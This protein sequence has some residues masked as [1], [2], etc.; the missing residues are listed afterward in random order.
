MEEICDWAG[1]QVF[2]GLDTKQGKI[3]PEKICRHMGR[4]SVAERV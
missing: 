2:L 1:R 4:R 3:V